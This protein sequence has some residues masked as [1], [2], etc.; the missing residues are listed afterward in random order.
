M[1]LLREYKKNDVE[2][3]RNLYEDVFPIEKTEEYWN[4]QFNNGI[5]GESTIVVAEEK[6]K[7]LGQVTMIPGNLT[8]KGKKFIGG[9]SIDAMVEAS[10]RREGIFEDMCNK[11]F[12][13]GGEREIDFIYG[14]PVFGALIGLLDKLDATI[15]DNIPIFMKVNN[16]KG[17]FSKVL[18]IP[19]LFKRKNKTTINLEEE[20]HEFEI[21]EVKEFGED[22]DHLWD[23]LKSNSQ[24]M[25]D[26]TSKFLNWRIKDHPHV[27][28][29]T[30]TAYSNNV[31]QGYIIL[32]LEHKVLKGGRNMIVGSIVDL[33]ALNTR[34]ADALL[35]EATTY[36]QGEE[37]DVVA[38]W[39][40]DSMI[41]KESL[42]KFNFKNSK[43]SI[44]LVVKE[45]RGNEYTKAIIS[46][47]N[48]W[49]MMPIESD[50]Y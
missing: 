12:Q 13:I 46:K 14:F 24:L 39:C 9:H 31:L 3:L 7:I 17:I 29:K 41:Y 28:Y 33:I 20:G 16:K 26:R 45:L 47:E 11:V 22:F 2:D 27:D 37:A 50:L 19:N 23:S 40:S 34:C 38:C 30:L 36:F 18:N 42:N 32:K 4:W 1:T 25:T 5:W 6:D 49:Y 43:T 44:A 15:V 35:Y 21:K 8:F 10:R 48:N